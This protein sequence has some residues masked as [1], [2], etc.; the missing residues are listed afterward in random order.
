[1]VKML[2]AIR[3][4]INSKSVVKDWNGAQRTVSV[5]NIDIRIPVELK[6]WTDQ[7]ILLICCRIVVA[8]V[9]PNRSLLARPDGDR[10][11][12]HTQVRIFNIPYI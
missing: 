3:A 5:I 6:G 8:H 12:G 2:T 11:P 10:V 9:H 4:D 1:M 7:P